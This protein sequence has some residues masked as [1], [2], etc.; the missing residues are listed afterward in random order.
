MGLK[1]RIKDWLDVKEP[2]AEDDSP[3]PKPK[4]G[5]R[6]KTRQQ[7]IEEEAKREARAYL[8]EMHDMKMEGYKEAI[9]LANMSSGLKMNQMIAQWESMLTAMQKI[10]NLMPQQQQGGL[11]ERI[12]AEAL[13]RI[14]ESPTGQ[15]IVGQLM[16][17]E[18]QPPA[19]TQ[20]RA[21]PVQPTNAVQNGRD[22]N[23]PA[24]SQAQPQ[25]PQ[26]GAP[27]QL[28]FDGF[29]MMLIPAVRNKSEPGPFAD[30]FATLAWTHRE[31]DT[32]ANAYRFMTRAPADVIIAQLI[33]KVAPGLEKEPH[34]KDWL[35]KFQSEIMKIEEGQT[36]EEV[37]EPEELEE[38]EEV[39]A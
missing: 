11:V 8:R 22:P 23:A 13:P 27:G 20:Q 26:I 10:G 28:A 14:L 7:L 6:K 24:E 18:A 2:P 15:K 34:V 16:G 33:P 38:S 9:E 25:R 31:D 30:I 17:G 37:E 12:V 32:F 19:S 29:L 36:V 1:S 4:P 21:N 5:P 39:A 35:I 3:E